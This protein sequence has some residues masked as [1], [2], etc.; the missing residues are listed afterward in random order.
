MVVLIA[1]R[2]SA[3]TQSGVG[4]QK[5]DHHLFTRHG[6][7]CILFH[8]MT[9]FSKRSF[10]RAVTQSI[11]VVVLIAARVSA[12]TQSGAGFQKLDHHSFIRQ[13]LL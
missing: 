11:Q 2:L 4:F 10:L 3:V 8:W 6:L 7:L 13:R 12:V 1:A 5:L 9:G